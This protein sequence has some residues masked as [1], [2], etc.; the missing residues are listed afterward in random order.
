MS[1]VDDWKN[2]SVREGSIVRLRQ[3][4]LRPEDAMAGRR[5]AYLLQPYQGF[6]VARV[7]KLDYEADTVRFT[8]CKQETAEPLK[9]EDWLRYVR[10]DY[11]FKTKTWLEEQGVDEY[12]SEVTVTVPFT[13]FDLVKVIEEDEWPW[14]GV[15]VDDYVY[16]VAEAA[17]WQGTVVGLDPTKQT[18]TLKRSAPN[19]IVEQKFPMPKVQWHHNNGPLGG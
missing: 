5:P 11:E 4:G 16:F 8:V 10:D 7:R 18:I 1:T 3:A 6:L 9:D 15:Y 2:S 13:D 19:G 17:Q 14:N 12:S